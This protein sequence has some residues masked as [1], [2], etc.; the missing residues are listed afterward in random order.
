MIYRP[1]HFGLKELVDRQT[2]EDH[3]ENAWN[4]LDGDLLKAL[5]ELRIAHSRPIYCND[6]DGGGVQQWRGYRPRYCTIGATQSMHRRG[7]AFDLTLEGLSGEQARELVREL[8]DSGKLQGIRRI[9][10]GVSWLHID[11][12]ATG[13]LGLVEFDP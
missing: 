10:R 6:W 1:K 13:R 4:L 3:G 9:E 12:K 5:D 7:M 2:F 8:H 11:S